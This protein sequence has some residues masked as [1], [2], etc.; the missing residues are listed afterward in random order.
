M[1]K[2]TKGLLVL[3]G[4]PFRKTHDLEGLPDQAVPHFPD[5]TKTIGPPVTLHSGF[6]GLPGR[7]SCFSASITPGSGPRRMDRF[8]GVDVR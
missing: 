3:A 4:V 6:E 5:L 8:G 7:F 1:E 2:L